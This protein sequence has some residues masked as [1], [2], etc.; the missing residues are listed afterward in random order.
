MIRT[1]TVDGVLVMTLDRPEARNAVDREAAASLST[2]LDR[3]VNDDGL[4]G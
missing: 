1:E 3:L 4:P 2:A